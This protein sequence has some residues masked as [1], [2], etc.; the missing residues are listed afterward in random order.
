MAG[1]AVP[2]FDMRRLL[3]AAHVPVQPLWLS[4]PDGNRFYLNV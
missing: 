1:A 3:P 4:D 2:A